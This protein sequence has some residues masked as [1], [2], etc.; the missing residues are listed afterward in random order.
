M[1]SFKYGLRCMVISVGSLI[2]DVY[3]FCGFLLMNLAAV[4][5][6]CLYCIIYSLH[7]YGLVEHGNL[8]VKSVTCIISTSCAS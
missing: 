5:A 4:V 1:N 8:I 6:L 7:A 2:R 3:L